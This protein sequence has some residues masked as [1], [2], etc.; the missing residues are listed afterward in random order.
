MEELSLLIMCNVLLGEH[1]KDQAL[2]YIIESIFH[3]CIHHIQVDSS[4]V[5]QCVR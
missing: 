1:L 5:W 2:H 4:V 3:L